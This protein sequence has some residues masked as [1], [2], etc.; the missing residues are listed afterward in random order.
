[1]ENMKITMGEYLKIKGCL[2]KQRGNVVYDNSK[3]LNAL[4]YVIENGCKWRSLPE[5]FGKWNSIYQRAR[6]WANSGTLEKVFLE[7]QKQQIIRIKLEHV[8]LDSTSIKVHPDAH[9]ALKNMEN[10]ASENR[11]VDGTQNFMW[12]PQMTK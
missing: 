3:F 4:L 6:R 9:G 7:L 1:M 8:S 12:S 10:N 5:N 11:A 2:P